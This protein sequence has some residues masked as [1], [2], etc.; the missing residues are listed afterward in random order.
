MY[1]G[2][3][4]LDHSLLLVNTQYC[5]AGQLKLHFPHL[6]HKVSQTSQK[7][8]GIPG[9]DTHIT[10]HIW[11][12][13]YPRHKEITVFSKFCSPIT[14]VALETRINGTVSFD[15]ARPTGKSEAPLAGGPFRPENFYL[16]R[17]VPRAFWH[18]SK[19]LMVPG[20]GSTPPTFLR[21]QWLITIWW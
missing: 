3:V 11:G 18:N 16:D 15:R 19:Q 7:I 13:G 20:Y 2:F 9:G 4:L 14:K 12:W 6:K 1:G 17:S 10:S 5:P 8:V 21:I